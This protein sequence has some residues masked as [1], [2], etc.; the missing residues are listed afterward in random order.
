MVACDEIVEGS[1]HDP[2]GIR[3][4]T[5]AIVGNR[6][7]AKEYGDPKARDIPTA[8]ATFAFLIASRSC[9]PNKV[10]RVGRATLAVVDLVRFS[11]FD[12][13][14]SKLRPPSAY[15]SPLQTN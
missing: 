4:C 11:L 14:P 10:S 3:P 15:L 7:C 1:L 8:H 13:V 6:S 12:G 9:P 5:E 2:Q